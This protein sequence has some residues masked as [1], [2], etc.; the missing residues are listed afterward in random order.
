M[1]VIYLRPLSN[2]FTEDFEFFLT[3]SIGSFIFMG[4]SIIPLIS[5]KGLKVDQKGVQ[6][7]YFPL[8]KKRIQTTNI[9]HIEI[10]ITRRNGGVKALIR[11]ISKKPRRIYK[12]RESGLYIDNIL[13]AFR[14]INV[15][16][17]TVEITK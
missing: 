4:I 16:I 17:K 9:D 3:G 7:V 2:I 8:I 13:N 10:K 1:E 12:L 5:V 14:W 15:P 11:I 6:I